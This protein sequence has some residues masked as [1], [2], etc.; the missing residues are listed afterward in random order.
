MEAE[1][2]EPSSTELSVRMYSRVEHSLEAAGGIRTHDLL[3]G[4]QT[5]Y[6]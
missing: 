3:L 5:L 6:S 2:I 1:G 4:K